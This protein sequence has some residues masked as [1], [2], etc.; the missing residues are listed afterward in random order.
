MAPNNSAA[1]PTIH[2]RYIGPYL[3]IFLFVPI[4]TFLVG[5]W[6]DATFLLP[7]FPPFPYN[8][9]MGVSI[10]LS[11]TAIG[12][13]ATR[14]LRSAGKGL[15]WGAFDKQAQSTL[16]V[17]TGIYS[18]T[19]NP[20]TLGYTLLPFGMGLLFRSL[21]MAVLIP[22]IIL[23]IMVIRI[24]KCEEPQLEARFGEEY[25]EYKHK[26]PFLIPRVLPIMMGLFT[27]QRKKQEENG[28]V[29]S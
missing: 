10:M 1:L 19:R 11:G 24:K 23:V 16:L 7:P 25:L 29:T 28:L 20:I 8:L 15:P 18:H 4:I 5:I 3:L 2:L 6:I 14:Q 26:T 22:L 27:R 12:I 13:K 21:G 17:T 9:I